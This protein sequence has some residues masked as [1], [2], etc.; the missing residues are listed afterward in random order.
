MEDGFSMDLVLGLS[1][2]RWVGRGRRE[3]GR[4]MALGW[5]KHI[6]AHFIPIIITSASYQIIRHQ[7]FEAG[8]LCVDNYLLP[9]SSGGPSSILMSYKDTQLYQVRAHPNDF[10]LS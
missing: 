4:G 2:D 8:N 5:F 3:Q 1:G 6:V 9:V 7:I 10:I